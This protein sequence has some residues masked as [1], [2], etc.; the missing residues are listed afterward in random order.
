VPP[1]HLFLV[2]HGESAWNAEARLQGQADP[3]LSERGVAEAGA[4]RDALAGV[5]GARLVTSDLERAWRTAELAGRGD[6]VRDARWRERDLGVW[7]ESLEGDVPAADL[8]A[9]RDGDFVPEGAESWER[10][11]AR[12][13]EAVDE[14]AGRGGSWLVFTHGGCVRAATAHVTG[15]RPDAI[16]GP[17]NASITLLELGPRRRLLA[18]NWT[19]SDGR[20]AVPRP[21]DPGANGA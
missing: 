9:F 3:P 20:I 2:R 7:T 10:F 19:A 16:A 5:T 11:Q 14:L 6:A 8:A 4:L 21:S 15:A 13:G 12:V 1:V 17:A 18:F